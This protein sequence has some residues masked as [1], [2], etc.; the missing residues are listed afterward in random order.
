MHEL[1]QQIVKIH[2]IAVCGRKGSENFI[3]AKREA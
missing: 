3:I 2:F 1:K